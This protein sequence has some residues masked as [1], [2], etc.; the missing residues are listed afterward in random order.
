MNSKQSKFKFPIKTTLLAI[1]LALM[2][3]GT[4]ASVQ[5]TRTRES[6]AFTVT[7]LTA[8][9]GGIAAFYALQELK[10][11]LETRNL[12]EEA[13][14]VERT[15]ALIAN[16]DEEQFAKAR[17]TIGELL[18]TMSG[19]ANNREVLRDRL[20]SDVTAKQDVT[21]ILNLLE[22]V[23]IFCQTGLLNEPLLRSFYR[24]IILRCWEVLEIY[25]ADRRNEVNGEIYE[26]L[27]ALYKD[28]SENP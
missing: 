12:E 15:M 18:Q 1:L 11:S 17:I 7:T 28:W 21:L 2:V 16:W 19:S 26:S 10:Q 6:I 8:A 14:K 25:V 3:S 27:E 20:K 24:P 4:Y 23:A 13:R 9:L 22:K 5:D